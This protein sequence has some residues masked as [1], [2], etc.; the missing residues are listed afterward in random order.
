VETSEGDVDAGEVVLKNDP[1]FG[2]PSPEQDNEMSVG[3][4][5]DVDDDLSALAYRPR[6]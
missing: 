4:V 1:I 2:P 3:D 5:M 6:H